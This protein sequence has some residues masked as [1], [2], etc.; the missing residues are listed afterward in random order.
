[1]ARRINNVAMHI[2]YKGDANL[3]AIHS[4][5]LQLEHRFSANHARVGPA[6]LMM[7]Y[8]G[9]PSSTAVTRIGPA[10]QVIT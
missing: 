6:A 10:W 1:M 3:K 9:T 5:A 8:S 7:E 4:I 2:E